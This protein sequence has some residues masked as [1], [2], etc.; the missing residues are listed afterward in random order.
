M[1]VRNFKF[2]SMVCQE[3]EQVG[4]WDCEIQKCWIELF[5]F[6]I[7]TSISCVAISNHMYDESTVITLH[8]ITLSLFHT[9]FTPK[10]T[11][12]ASTKLCIFQ[13]KQM[14]FKCL[15]KVH[16]SVSSWR[17]GGGSFHAFGR[18]VGGFLVTRMSFHDILRLPLFSRYWGRFWSRWHFQFGTAPSL[19][20]LLKS[21]ASGCVGA[22]GLLFMHTFTIDT[23]IPKNEF[24]QTIETDNLN[25]LCSIPWV[26]SHTD[27]VKFQINVFYANC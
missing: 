6:L 14:S 26:N 20:A 3:V 8:Y 24:R 9:P 27:K 13:C 17:A 23:R 4:G 7:W 15:L 22:F 11:S 18:Y 12:G 19:F 5:Y 2:A 16:V 25:R 10:V 1:D 21:V